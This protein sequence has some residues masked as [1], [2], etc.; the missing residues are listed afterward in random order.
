MENMT[1]HTSQSNYTDINNGW[2]TKD[3]LYLIPK[4]F[5]A[6]F[7]NQKRFFRLIQYYRAKVMGKIKFLPISF[8]T[9]I[10]IAGRNYKE[11]Q[12]ILEEEILLDIDPSYMNFVGYSHPKRFKLKIGDATVKD[13]ISSEHGPI[14]NYCFCFLSLMCISE[15]VAITGIHRQRFY[16]CRKDYH[17][18]Y[19]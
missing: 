2:I 8:W 16:E 5:F 7:I 11:F 3:D 12:K 10:Y 14:Q 19:Q 4:I 13:M 18:D 1:L 15:A 9:W 17:I 6:D